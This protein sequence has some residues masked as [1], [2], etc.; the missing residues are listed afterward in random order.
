MKKV[1][2]TVAEF[3]ENG[4]QLAEGRDVYVMI[5]G[6]IRFDGKIKLYHDG[7]WHYDDQVN[8]EYSELAYDDYVQIDCT[9]H[10][11]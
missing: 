8:T 7:N 10:Y 5:R 11:V 6:E 4:G 3:L 1:F 2:V 9:P